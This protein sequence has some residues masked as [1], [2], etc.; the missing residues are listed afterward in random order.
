MTIDRHTPYDELPEWMSIDEVRAY[1]DT[2]R[3]ATYEAARSGKWPLLKVG[4]IE[5]VHKSAFAPQDPR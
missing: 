4:R 3:S 2:G 1:L 5:R